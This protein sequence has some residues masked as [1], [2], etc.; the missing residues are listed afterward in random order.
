MPTY[1][2]SPF[3][4][5]LQSALVIADEIDN[6]GTNDVT[7]APGSIAA[8]YGINGHA[9]VCYL[10]VYDNGNPTLGTD[11]PDWIFPFQNN[12]AYTV[13]IDTRANFTNALSLIGNLFVGGAAGPS[14]TNLDIR[15]FTSSLV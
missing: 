14:P 5:D 7:G 10:N 4:T 12:E 15:V 8:I 11:D 2:A 6:A 3:V 9:E 1:K 13:C